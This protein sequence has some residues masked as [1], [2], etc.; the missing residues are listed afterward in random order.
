MFKIK[1][2]IKLYIKLNLFHNFLG[3]Y[4]FSPKIAHKLVAY[5]E[6]EAVRTY[7]HVLRDIDLGR[8]PEFND[9]ELSQEMRD[10]WHLDEKATFRDLILCIRADEAIH[11]EVNKD[12]S[13]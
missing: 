4:F 7:T 2:C 5:L 1:Y 12:L 6:E 11:R 13:V 3:H 8:V 9:F 10:Y